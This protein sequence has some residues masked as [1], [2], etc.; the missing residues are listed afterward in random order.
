[1]NPGQ[2]GPVPMG[3]NRKWGAQSN[4]NPAPSSHSQVDPETVQVGTTFSVHVV[5]LRL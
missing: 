2:A 5:I 4:A 1:M 3:S